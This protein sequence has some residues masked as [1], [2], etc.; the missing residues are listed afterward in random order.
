[1]PQRSGRLSRQADIQGEAEGMADGSDLDARQAR[2]D[3][4]GREQPLDRLGHRQ[5]LPRPWR[6]SRL[7]LSGRGAQEA[8]RAAGRGSGRHRRRPLR[9]HRAGDHRRRLRRACSKPGAALDFVVHAIAFSDKDELDG[10][11]VDTTRRQFHQ[12]HAD[13]LL[14][15]HRGRAAR[16]EAD[17]EWRLAAD[18]DLLRRRESGCRITT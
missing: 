14:L 9:R 17:D 8:R 13:L 11:Y 4:G 10:R 1:M 6:R 3:H 7:H 2:P 5:G 18:A 16:R 12:D 15:V